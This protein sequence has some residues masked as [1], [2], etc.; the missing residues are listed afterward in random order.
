MVS[1]GYYHVNNN[2][3]D[4]S[5]A[6][7]TQ[8]M[9]KDKFPYHGDF[10]PWGFLLKMILTSLRKYH[11]DDGGGR[12]GEASKKLTS[13]DRDTGTAVRSGRF[14]AW[15]PFCSRLKLQSSRCTA[16]ISEVRPALLHVKD[17]TALLGLQN[18][19]SWE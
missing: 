16:I 8:W 9:P 14:D 11:Q 19:T 3:S 7:L 17:A 5:A 6:S 10:F 4:T 1:L 15:L 12:N 13:K 2:T 18:E